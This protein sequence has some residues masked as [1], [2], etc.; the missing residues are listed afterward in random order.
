MAMNGGGSRNPFKR[1]AARYADAALSGRLFGGGGSTSTGPKRL[2]AGKTTYGGGSSKPNKI[3]SKRP[4]A[5]P[6]RK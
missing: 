5:N 4:K 2:K 6:R 3:T 1:A